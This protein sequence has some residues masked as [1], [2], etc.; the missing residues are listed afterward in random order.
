MS[1]FHWHLLNCSQASQY[2]GLLHGEEVSEPRK[3]VVWR[4]IVL[5]Q[6]QLF[7]AANRVPFS[8]N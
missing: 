4:A 8:D 5:K 7:P 2:P 1:L 6:V 3:G